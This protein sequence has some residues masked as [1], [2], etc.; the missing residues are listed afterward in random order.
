MIGDLGMGLIRFIVHP[1]SL[2][3]DWPEVH[4]GYLCGADGRVFPTRIEV[5]GNVVLCR[6]NTSESCKF[7]VGWPIEGFGRPVTGTASLPEREEPYLLAVELARGKI[8]Q[9]RNQA[10]QWE[11]AGMQIP[12]EFQAPS[13]EAHRL[14]AR[15]ASAQDDPAAASRMA[16]DALTLACQAAD[17]LTE[18]YAQQALAGRHQRYPQLPAL[19]GCELGGEPPA[20]DVEDLFL[21]TFNAAVIR[22]CWNDIESAEG[23]Y[24]WD[25]VDRQLAWCE[26]HK[27]KVRAGSLIDLG[28]GGLPPWLSNWEHDLLNVQSFVCDFVETALAR[29]LGRIRSW[30]I[31]ARANSGGAMTLNEENRLTLTARVL[32]IARQVDEEAQ[33]FIRVDQPWGDY[34][35][36]GQHR[37]SP[38]QL[39]DALIRSGVGLAG[40]NLEIACGYLP[41][42]SALR[43]LLDV[44]RMVDSWGVLQVPLHI[45]L[46]C[47]SSSVAD[48]LAAPDQEVDPHFWPRPA[49]E[50]Q[51]ANWLKQ[52]V[53][54]LMAKPAVASVN[55]STWTDSRPHEFPHAGLLRADDTP[56]A[57]LERGLRY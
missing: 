39:T 57:A 4:R 15:A 31:V 28:P 46:A 41:R 51:Q 37:L 6:R 42:G 18:S 36:R 35:A 24:D 47:P 23:D 5:E 12:A 17:L 11:V 13:L 27:L 53:P 21:K 16:N 33:L 19:L 40:V 26:A 20:S 3:D 56:K 30:E 44:S 50:T 25:A 45:T 2:L 34:Q 49:D 9:I 10:S 14:F 29:Y 54:L 7:H 1:A 22:C 55:W 32:D 43:D 52:F 38:L 8:V 48:P